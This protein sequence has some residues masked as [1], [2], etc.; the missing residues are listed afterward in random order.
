MCTLPRE[1]LRWDLL[2]C[3]KGKTLDKGPLDGGYPL[4]EVLY[5]GKGRDDRR[6]ECLKR[7]IYVRITGG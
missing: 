4:G 2:R 1:G 7:V 6:E 5:H 3:N